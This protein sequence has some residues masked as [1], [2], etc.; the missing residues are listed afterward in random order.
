MNLAEKGQP[1]L[2]KDFGL[3]PKLLN[4]QQRLF[5]LIWLNDTKGGCTN[6]GASS[7]FFPLLS[8]GQ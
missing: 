3:I 4:S 1:F 2:N 5:I 8:S 6:N 7:S